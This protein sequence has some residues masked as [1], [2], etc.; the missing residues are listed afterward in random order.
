MAV[1]MLVVVLP[2]CGMALVTMIT[3]GGAPSEDSNSEVRNAR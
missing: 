2:S 3:R 1:L